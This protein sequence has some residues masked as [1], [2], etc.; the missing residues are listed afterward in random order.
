MNTHLNNVVESERFQTSIARGRAMS[1][2]I[3]DG[4]AVRFDKQEKRVTSGEIYALWS[5]I[6]GLIFRRLFIEKDA[7]RVVAD[8][9]AFPEIKIARDEKNIGSRILGKVT[10]LAQRY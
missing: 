8:N 9:P 7:V 4:A 6:E 5:D 1:P 10:G 2:T 3:I